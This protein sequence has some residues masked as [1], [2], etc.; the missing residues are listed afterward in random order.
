MS[1]T[2]DLL[3]FKDQVEIL[4]VGWKAISPASWEVKT[5]PEAEPKASAIFLIRRGRE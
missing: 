2:F 3:S 1:A 5:S 4:V